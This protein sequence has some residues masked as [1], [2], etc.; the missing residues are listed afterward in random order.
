MKPW[1]V[2]S[3]EE[4]SAVSRVLKSGK[5]N[6]LFGNNGKSFEAEF[7]DFV[8]TKFS[9]ALANGTLALDIALRAI[10][11]EPGDE[12]IVTPR[13]YI[14]S[15]S[16]VNLLGAKPVFA[17][18]DYNS[19]NISV[20]TISK[21]L[22]KKT[23]AVICVHL[24]GMPCEMDPIMDLAYKKNFIVI[25]D[26]AQ[27]HGATYKG[28]SVGSIG[29]IGAWSFC[30]DKIM[31]LGGEGGMITTNVKKYY[32][33]ATSFNN[34]GKN[35]KKISSQRKNKVPKFR[36]VHDSIGSN[37]R[38]TE[39]QSSIG[40]IQLKKMKKWSDIR[41]DN[42]NQIYQSIAHIP[43]AVLPIIPE[44]MSHAFYK[45]YVMLDKKFLKSGWSRDKIIFEINHRGVDCFSGSCPEIYL[46]KSYNKNR[47]QNRLPVSKKLGE[48]SLMF[49]V[50]PSLS[51]KDI[52]KSKTVI[53]KVLEMA[54][55]K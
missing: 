31:T 18:V 28:K 46:E 20:D 48:D 44:H 14:A 15:A 1:P 26:C 39:M 13:S 12:V 34:H 4:I 3:K 54:S 55:K 22:T 2:Y 49:T 45:C 42:A 41:Q 35:F 7:S 47:S 6:Y 16:C 30:N 53:R 50:H 38:M 33:F 5:V 51:K 19:Q 8:G 32:D 43:S 40:R 23:K 10:N 27:A 17:D 24:A 52:I 21:C 9:L 11:I 25:E 37:Y 29:H 36:Y